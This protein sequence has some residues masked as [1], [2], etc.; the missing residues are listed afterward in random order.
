M[1]NKARL[2][3]KAF[4][5]I[6]A[7]G[8]AIIFT[9]LFFFSSGCTDLRLKFFS[10]CKFR[11]L[12]CINTGLTQHLFPNCVNARRYRQFNATSHESKFMT[13]RFL[14][15]ASSFFLA[16]PA[17][18]QVQWFPAQYNNIT[19]QYILDTSSAFPVS[20]IKFQNNKVFMYGHRTHYET[21]MKPK[22]N[23][24]FS[25][26]LTIP[27]GPTETVRKSYI[28]ATYFFYTNKNIGKL[29]INRSNKIDTI[30]FIKSIKKFKDINVKWG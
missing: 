22:A 24:Y 23:G 6:W 28:N 12:N 21:P 26:G 5:A 11:L 9:Q 13:M 25:N 18:G 16:F 17:A 30:I 10:N 15:I 29:I 2:T 20:F 19:N 27:A 1:A 3:T 14:I 4:N 7:D 8:S